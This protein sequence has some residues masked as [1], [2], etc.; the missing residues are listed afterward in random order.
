MVSKIKGQHISVMQG[1]VGFIAIA[2]FKFGGQ[3]AINFNHIKAFA[4]ANH[5]VSKRTMSGPNLNDS[6]I[7]FQIQCLDDS[8][9]DIAIMQE[10]LAKAFAGS[11]FCALRHGCSSVL[12]FPGQWRWRF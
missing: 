7:C 3:I 10:V 8:F 2:P 12:P 11:V 5:D 1:E 6:I 4:L 9:N